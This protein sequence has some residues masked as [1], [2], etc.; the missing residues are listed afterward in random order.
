MP[1]LIRIKYDNAREEASLRGI[2]TLEGSITKFEANLKKNLGAWEYA[3]IYHKGNKFHYYHHSTGVE[4]LDYE[5]YKKQINKTRINLYIVP[6]QEY[7]DRT[8]QQR[9]KPV[10]GA[11]IADMPNYYNDD[12]LKVL[13][14]LNNRVIRTYQDGK[15]L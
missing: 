15:F 7:K 5:Q 1:T 9:F 11:K 2:S 6:T 3:I 13:A 12:V 10:Y 4:K 14:Y 8:G